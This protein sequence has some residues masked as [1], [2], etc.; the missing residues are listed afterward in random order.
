[1]GFAYFDA[2]DMKEA[3]TPEHFDKVRGSVKYP[4]K[5]AELQALVASLN[6]DDNPVV[7]IAHLKK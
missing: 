2:F 6:E 3:L 4:E 7:A 5:L 1:M